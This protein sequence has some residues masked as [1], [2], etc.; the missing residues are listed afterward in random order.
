MLEEHGDQAEQYVL[1][2]LINEIHDGGETVAVVLDDWHRVSNAAT[3][4]ALEYLLDHGC[5]HLRLMVTSR[6]QAGLPLSRMRVRDELVEID[7]TA[8]R[9]D[10][11]ETRHF[12]VNS[13]AS[14]STTARSRG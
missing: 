13:A 9:F 12:L 5:Q 7:A 3:V 10:V 4:A 14:T 6:T 8:L 11:A 1:T 2:S